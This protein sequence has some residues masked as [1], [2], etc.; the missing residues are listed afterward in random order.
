MHK[1]SSK[2]FIF[3]VFLTLCFSVI[4]LNYYNLLIVPKKI[5]NSTISPILKPTWKMS[6]GISGAF[7]FVFDLKDIYSENNHLKDSNQ[8]LIEENSYLKELFRQKEFLDTAK[9]LQAKENFQWQ[10]GN[11]VGM[12][13]QNMTGHLIVDGGEEDGITL[14][15]PVI[16]ENKFLVGKVVE[17]DKNFSKVL[18]IFNPSIKIAVKT[19]DSQAQGL[20][21]GNYSKKMA[22]DLIPKDKELKIGEIVVTSG[23]DAVFPSGLIV[24]QIDGFEI[25]PENL[26]Q[27]AH[28]FS[29]M[30][31][32]D[33]NQVIILT[34]W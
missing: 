27:V 4:I 19:Q 20:L 29:E 5:F 31:I 26:F 21:N 7:S 16:T 11:V 25:K 13:I 9:N 33:L 10:I 17:V 2:I 18:T 23:K 28:A 6:G 3:S 30:N 1:K 12:D 24:G 32:Y 8:K 14:D 34:S 15:M 22:I